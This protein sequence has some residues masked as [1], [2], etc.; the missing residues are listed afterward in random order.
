MREIV[1]RTNVLVSKEEAYKA[2][3]TSEGINAFFGEDS[4][5]E[6]KVNGTFEVYFSKSSQVGFRGSEG[7]Q[8]IQF[9][10]NEFVEFSW[11]VPPVFKKEREEN[12]Q[13]IVRIDFI[14]ISHNVTEVRLTNTYQ[15]KTE[16]LDQIMTYFDSAW[17]YVLDEFTKVMN[18]L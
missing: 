13:S 2:W 10:E 18:H 3:T 11:N 17:D 1:K 8:I 4:N 6:L 15:K 16:S 14:S 7:C 12:Y 9:K 5:I